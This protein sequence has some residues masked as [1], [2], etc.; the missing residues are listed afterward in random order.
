MFLQDACRDLVALLVSPNS[1][2]IWNVERGTKVAKCTFYETIT[3]ME[4][5]PFNSSF[6]VC[7]LCYCIVLNSTSVVQSSSEVI[8]MSLLYFNGVYNMVC[9]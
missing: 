4:F 7:K 2:S 1:L 3:H 5:D 8:M 6:L 9:T